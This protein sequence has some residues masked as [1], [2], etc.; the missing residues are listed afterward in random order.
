MQQYLFGLLTAFAISFYLIPVI[1]KI[2]KTQ[3]LYDMPNERKVHLTP[4]STLGGMAIFLGFIISLLLNVR[5]ISAIPYFH[6]YLIA[7][8]ILF[9]LGLCDDMIVLP[10]L[11]KF[12]GQLIVSFVLIAKGHLLITN[13]HGFLGIEELASPFNYLFTYLTIISIINAFNLIDGIDGLAG[14][15]GIIS[16]LVFG[17][18]FA[19]NNQPLFAFMAFAFSGSL[20]AF[21]CFNISPAKI[22]MGD[23]GSMLIGLINAILVIEFIQEAPSASIFPFAA[24]PAIGFGIL[25]IPLMD[26]ARVFFNRLS[27]GKSP[28]YADKTHFHHLLLNR[29]FSHRTATFTMAL[30]SILILSVTYAIR[31]WPTTA[32]IFTQVLLFFA[33]VAGIYYLDRKGYLHVIKQPDGKIVLEEELATQSWLRKIRTSLKKIGS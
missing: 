11:K 23:S 33:G 19:L 3:K 29:G 27:K 8:I 7:F 26:T 30:F 6:S 4:I 14:T 24:S 15:L 17:V 5:G 2:S 31:N 20:L 22:F 25:L 10:P 28:F 1:I 13:L 9:F 18:W 21:L 32:I 16:S 12:A